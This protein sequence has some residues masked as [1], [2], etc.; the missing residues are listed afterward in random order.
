MAFDGITIANLVY[1]FKNKILQCHISK[2]A[3]PEK[4]ELILTLKGSETHRL[5]LCADPT[6]PLVYLTS[7]NKDNPLTAPNFC[8]LLRK[9]FNGARIIDINQPGLE[10]AIDFTIEHNDEFFDKQIK[11]LIIEIMGKHSNIILCDKDYTIIDAVKRIPSFVSSVRE[12]LPGR[13]YFLPNTENKL[14][15]LETDK[16]AFFEAIHKPVPLYKAIYSS[17]TGISPLIANEICK[18]AIIES[19]SAISLDDTQLEVLYQAFSNLIKEIKNNAYS[20]AIYKNEDGF[21]DYSVLLL[22]DKANYEVTEYESVSTLLENFYKAKNLNT[23]IKQKSTDLRKLIGNLLERETKKLELQLASQKDTEKR[24]TFKL[25]GELLS[26][27]A[28]NLETGLKKAVVNNYYTNEDITIPLDEQLTPLENVK[29]YYDKYAKLKR[30]HEALIEQI[31][32][33][34]EAKEELELLRFS[35]EIARTEEDLNEIKE[36]LIANGFV[37]KQIIAG[38]QNKKNQVKKKTNSFLHFKTKDGTDIYVGKNNLQNEELTLKFAKGNDW[39]FHAKKMPGSHVIC[40]N[41]TQNSEM[42]DE[43][44]EI[45]GS[46]AAYYSTGNQ[47]PKTEVDY[48]QK[49][50]IKKPQGSALGFVIYHEN[51][52]LMAVPKSPEALG[53]TE[54]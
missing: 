22:S 25:Y 8:M 1:E 3:Q 28:Y 42:P 34:K 44:Y 11:H 14:N 49:K 51:Y 27:Y 53:L 52:S 15:P 24:D 5:F 43:I 54:I 47:A 6:L 13:H 31:K 18:R 26:V 37:K 46:L 41:N 48:L 16:E 33:T 10:R 2:I 38:K 35:L 23:K 30:T 21:F 20:P 9:Y 29:R 17:F 32:T 19:E 39:W 36:E 4:D 50:H 45:C 40:I 7:E 12:V